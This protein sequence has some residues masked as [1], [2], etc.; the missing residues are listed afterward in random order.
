MYPQKGS[1]PAYKGH[2]QSPTAVSPHDVSSSIAVLV[3]HASM[4]VE[5]TPQVLQDLGQAF[6]MKPGFFSHSPMD[7]QYLQSVLKP[8]SPWVSTQLS[9][10]GASVS[11][12]ASGVTSA[13]LFSSSQPRDQVPPAQVN[14]QKSSAPSKIGHAHAPMAAAS[15]E[16]PTSAAPLPQ[17]AT[18]SGAVTKG[19]AATNDAV[20]ART[21]MMAIRE[22]FMI[23]FAL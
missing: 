21:W 4:Q 16:P 13:S 14:E 6:P 19:A 1:A 8:Q 7:A 11:G 2:R 12:K 3:E 22:D 20:A 5:S 17:G 10:T 18:H 9:A 15:H 23:V